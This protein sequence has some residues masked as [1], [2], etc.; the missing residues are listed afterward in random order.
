MREW[1]RK[2]VVGSE[3]SLRACLSDDGK[4]HNSREGV[5]EHL[6]ID[7]GEPRLEGEEERGTKLPEVISSASNPAVLC[8]PIII[9]PNQRR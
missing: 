5:E 9:S 3:K 6:I 1:R 2:A 4:C 8:A 7:G